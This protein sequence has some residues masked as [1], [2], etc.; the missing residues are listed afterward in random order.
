[1]FFIFVKFMVKMG[2][3]VGIM[4]SCPSSGL[5]TIKTYYIYAGDNS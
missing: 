1:M 3:N 5:K 4:N 2:A